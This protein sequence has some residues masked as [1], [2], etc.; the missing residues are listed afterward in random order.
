MDKSMETNK[1]DYIKTANLY[2]LD[3]RD[4]LVADIPFY[5]E[6]A[7]RYKGCI[8]ELGCG[9]GR[10]SIELAKAGYFITGLDLSQKMLEVYEG[11]IKTLSKD[12]QNRINIINGNMAN[13][14]LDK[15]YSLI[16]APFR[17]FQLLTVEDEINNCLNC[18]WKHLD[19]DGIFIVNVFRPNIILDESWCSGERIQW[20]REDPITGNLVIKK[21]VRERIDTIQQI[22]YPK[23]I[24]EVKDKEGNI[25]KITENLQLKYYYYDQL[26]SKLS[27]ND[28]DIIEEYGWY[29]KSPIETGRELI[30][31]CKQKRAYCV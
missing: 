19:D 1:H 16:I 3:Q 21:D 22:I 30:M 25:E 17:V 31:V 29:D 9:T 18:I 4:N 2:D 13:F 14:N 6:Y 5:L 27:S 12:V 8:L 20:E 26:K 10:V 24:Y 11:K 15:K 7:H 28:F 23:F